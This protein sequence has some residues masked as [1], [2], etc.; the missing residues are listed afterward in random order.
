MTRGDPGRDLFPNRGKGFQQCYHVI[1]GGNGR[2][3]KRGPPTIVTLSR[4]V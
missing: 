1:E 4:R 3:A 2:N